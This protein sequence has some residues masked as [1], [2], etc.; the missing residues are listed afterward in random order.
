MGEVDD[1]RGGDS[2]LGRGALG[3]P[4]HDCGTVRVDVGSVVIHV[5]TVLEPIAHDHM[6][7]GQCQRSVRAGVRSQVDVGVLGRPAAV[8]ID[9]DQLG[10]GPLACSADQLPRVDRRRDRVH[11]PHD[12]R[13]GI[14]QVLRIRPRPTRDAAQREPLRTANRTFQLR[15]AEPVEQR[16]R[17]PERIEQ[18]HR[19]QVGVPQDRFATMLLDAVAP[20]I[21]DLSE[22]LV[23]ADRVEIT[24]PLGS[25]APHRREHPR[26]AVHPLQIPVDLDAQVSSGDRVRTISANLGRPSRYIDR[27]QRAASVGTIVRASQP[28]NHVVHR[29]PP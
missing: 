16:L 20:A 26:R 9:D 5:V 13:L 28:N 17:R 24:T 2:R 14:G 7:D 3:R 11:A 29:R 21:G 8:R 25:R 4:F 10:T 15:C 1:L 23:P 19:P 6:P 18:T 12:D 22:R 27:D